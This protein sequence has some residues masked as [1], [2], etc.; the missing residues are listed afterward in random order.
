MTIMT[1]CFV[2]R[3]GFP[4]GLLH[5]GSSNASLSVVADA[6][7]AVRCVINHP[8][9]CKLVVAACSDLAVTSSNSERLHQLRSP[10]LP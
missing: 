4:F 5:S 1:V 3:Y 10:T 9:C 7:T 6:D 8:S 2:R